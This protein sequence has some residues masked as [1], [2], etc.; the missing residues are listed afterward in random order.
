MKNKKLKIILIIISCI[1]ILFSYFILIKLAFNY[2]LLS[3]YY[4]ETLNLVIEISN[5]QQ[6]VI[7]NNLDGFEEVFE[8]NLSLYECP[9][10]KSYFET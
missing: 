9:L 7:V 6:E 3:Q 5:L 8:E 10:G 1:L 4:C 2:L